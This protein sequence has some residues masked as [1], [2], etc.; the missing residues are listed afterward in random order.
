MEFYIK[1]VHFRNRLNK[2]LWKA[3]PKID[4]DHK[5]RIIPLHLSVDIKEDI[6]KPTHPTKKCPIQNWLRVSFLV[7]EKK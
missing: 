4:K 6:I 7:K 2:I 5:V 3:L 1:F